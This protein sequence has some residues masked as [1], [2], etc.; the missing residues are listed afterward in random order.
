MGKNKKQINRKYGWRPQLPDQRDFQ[1]KSSF[2]IENLPKSVDLRPN[3]PPV[4]DQGSLGSCTANAIAG[5]IEFEQM[6]EKSSLVFTPSRLFI[7]FNERVMEN[8][9]KSDAGAVIRDGIKSVN[10]NGVCKETTWPYI[11]K[12]FAKKPTNEAY[13]EGLKYKTLVYSAVGQD[14]NSVK[15]CLSNGDPIVFGFVVFDGLENLDPAKNGIIP[16]PSAQDK[17]IGGHAV[18]AVGYNDDTEQIIIRNSWGENWGDKGFGYM[19]YDY[20]FS[21]LT[22]DFWSIK[23]V[24]I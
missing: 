5:A 14:Q 2:S 13:T 16:T 15:S 22:S 1:Y 10:N 4:Y 19:S 7:Y 8:T 20:F 21:Q 11:E 24:E 9:I 6:K 3:C 18:L 17:S 23:Q 12:N